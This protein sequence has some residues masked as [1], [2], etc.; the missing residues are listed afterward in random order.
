M[1]QRIATMRR[2]ILLITLIS[3]EGCTTLRPIDGNS[4]ELQER[5]NSAGLLKVAIA[6]AHAV[7]AVPLGREHRRPLSAG[8]AA[9]TVTCRLAGQSLRAWF[10][11]RSAPDGNPHR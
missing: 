9:L 5:I 4:G 3:F 7:P 11:R 2:F 8:A 6:A 10:A 1:R